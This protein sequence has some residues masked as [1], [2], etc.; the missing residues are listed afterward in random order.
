[1]QSVKRP[2][3]KKHQ[4]ENIQTSYMKCTKKQP[5]RK[6]DLNGIGVMV[7]GQLLIEQPFQKSIMIMLK[8]LLKNQPTQKKV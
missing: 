2:T 5:V 8:Q 7:A 6:K 3:K 4:Q 1:M